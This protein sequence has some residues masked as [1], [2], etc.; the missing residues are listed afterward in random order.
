MTFLLHDGP[1]LQRSSQSQISSLQPI[2]ALAVGLSDLAK[3]YEQSGDATSAEAALQMVMN[4]G[5]H[6][7]DAPGEMRGRQVWPEMREELEAI[8]KKGSGVH[9][10][11]ASELY[12]E[13]DGG[14]RNPSNL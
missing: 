10:L 5:Q 6:Y 4:L 12:H 7:S 3:S 13:R 2:K 14:W 8:G 11:Y 1:T 9:F